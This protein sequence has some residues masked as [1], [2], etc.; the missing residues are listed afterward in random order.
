MNYTI[1]QYGASLRAS[2]LGAE[3]CSYIDATGQERIWP[4]QADIWPGHAPVL[5]PLV[6]APKNGEV[7]FAGKAYPVRKHGFLASREFTLVEQGANFLHF[8]A[9]ADEETR[10]S[11]PY[12]F[13]VHILHFLRPDGFTTE[14]RVQNCDIRPMPYCIGGHPGFCCPM[15]PDAVFEDYLLR[16]E[17]PETG[18]IVVCPDGG[19]VRGHEFLPALAGG[20]EL[21]LSHIYFA[22]KAAVIF[23]ALASRQVDL[24]PR[25]S[26]RGIRFQF[27]DFDVLGVWT[28]PGV[29]ADY[30]CLEPW[31]GLNAY[32][33]ET[34]NFEDKPFVRTVQ[35]GETHTLRY[36]TTLLS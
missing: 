2:T 22:E 12:A 31:V 20:Q 1:S 32:A 15:E 7:R 9:E 17:K 19:L 14:F 28:K 24:I 6:G 27:A 5:F 8:A 30:L 21:P 4:G 18:E 11:Y 35:P 25:E 16:F 23:P 26:R 33:D 34:G 13:A 29:R 36:S 10:A 3:L